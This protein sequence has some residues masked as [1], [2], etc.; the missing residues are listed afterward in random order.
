MK[1]TTLLS[2]LIS[3]TPTAKH[4]L[5][6]KPTKEDVH[7]NINCWIQR[8]F[9]IICLAA[10]VSLLLIFV[11]VCYVLVGVSATESGTYYNHIRGVI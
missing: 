7:R 1:F 8:N 4:S 11:V 6:K 2:N 5:H 10:I 9:Y 3:E